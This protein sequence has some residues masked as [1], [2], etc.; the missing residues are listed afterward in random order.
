MGR[1]QKPQVIAKSKRA[2]H[3]TGTLAKRSGDPIQSSGKTGEYTVNGQPYGD[4]LPTSSGLREIVRTKTQ[5]EGHNALA[6]E[7]QSKN[8]AKVKLYGFFCRRVNK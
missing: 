4:I 5:E 2:N 7:R 3:Y 8:E 6:P 1:N